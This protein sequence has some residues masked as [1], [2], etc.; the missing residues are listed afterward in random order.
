MLNQ[1]SLPRMFFFLFLRPTMPTLLNATTV[2]FSHFFSFLFFITFPLLCFVCFFPSHSR[3]WSITLFFFGAHVLP[4]RCNLHNGAG[5]FFFLCCC[6]TSRSSRLCLLLRRRRRRH[7]MVS[8][9]PSAYLALSAVSLLPLTHVLLPI[10]SESPAPAIAYCAVCVLCIHP[11]VFPILSRVV[12]LLYMGLTPAT[13]RPSAIIYTIL[14]C[15]VMI[16]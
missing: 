15:Y 10:V 13:N 6:C 2:F 5:T 3:L 7:A 12:V 4:G 14:L 16:G 1:N 9:P 8:S 11:C